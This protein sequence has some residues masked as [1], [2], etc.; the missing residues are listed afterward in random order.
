[1]GIPFQ[2]IENIHISIRSDCS[3][4]FKYGKSRPFPL[5]S[6]YYGE[7]K[8]NLLPGNR[9]LKVVMLKWMILLALGKNSDV[10]YIASKLGNQKQKIFLQ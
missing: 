3:A 8:N 1:M 7:V 2:E 4:W 5:R 10:R 9:F 6:T